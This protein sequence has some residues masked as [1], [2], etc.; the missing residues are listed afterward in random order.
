MS[1]LSR[2]AYAAQRRAER[3]A[4]DMRTERGL[5]HHP[6]ASGWAVCPACEG[7]GSHDRNDS[8]L[9][10]PQCGYTVRCGT[11][12]GDGYVR[13]GRAPDLLLALRDAR[14]AAL[15]GREA[16]V[17]ESLRRR[18]MCPVSGLAQA[19]MLAMA[20]RCVTAARRLAA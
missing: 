14:A 20:T 12:Y 8:P 19:D 15:R 18:A 6:D 3:D 10:D 2:S 5:P 11:C 17:Y 7:D 13:D 9:N 1:Q 4:R 16:F